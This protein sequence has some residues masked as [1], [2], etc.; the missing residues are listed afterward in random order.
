MALTQ[1]NLG[2]VDTAAAGGLGMRNRIIN[3]AMEIDQ[4][5]AGA[6]SNPD[7]SYGIDR[8]YGRQ[9]GGGVFSMQQS[10]TV[11]AGFSKSMALTVTT[12]DSSI[13]TS[14]RYVVLQPIEGYN[15]ADLDWGTSNAKTITISFWARSSITGNHSIALRNNTPDRFYGTTYS[16]SSADTWEYKT[17][18]I[19][20]DTSG[21]WEKTN[22]AGITL[23]FGLGGGPT[24]TTSTNDAWVSG[25][26]L[27]ATG[28]VNLIA[29]NSATLYITGVQLEVGSVATEFE[30]RPYGTELALCQR[31]Y[32]RNFNPTA[33]VIGTASSAVVIPR[34]AVPMRAA[35]TV[36]AITTATIDLFGVAVV[37]ASSTNFDSGTTTGCRAYYGGMSGSTFGQPCHLT[38]DAIQA[39]AEL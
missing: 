19:S 8:W 15:C 3:G 7:N 32:Q 16:I 35:P 22:S 39:S 6:S 10:S 4:R 26:Y 33:G 31:Y 17:I 18:S 5:N 37:S 14:D 23:M 12:A 20:G 9:V 13:V 2:M 1:V 21:T 11:P 36:S 28:A 29:T 27:F 24:Y 38:N 30:R 34:F 25:N